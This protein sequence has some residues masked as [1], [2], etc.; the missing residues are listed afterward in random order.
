MPPLPRGTCPVC[1]ANVAL[2]KGRLVRQ[3][4]PSSHWV[5]ARVLLN[6]KVTP[7]CP[8]TGKKAMPDG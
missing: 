5:R 1:R 7:V 6:M 8:G 2:R 4:Q 3:H